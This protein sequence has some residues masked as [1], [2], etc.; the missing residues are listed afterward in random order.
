MRILITGSREWDDAETL[1]ILLKRYYDRDRTAVLIHGNGRGCDKQA[2]RIWKAFGGHAVPYH[3]QWNLYGKSAGPKRNQQMVN[4]GATV[5][6]AFPLGE[7]RGTRDCMERAKK[8]GIPV[9]NYGD[10][11]PV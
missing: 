2:A 1:A 8:A 11:D 7:S 4:D 5:C 10:A 6:L 3:A 9:L